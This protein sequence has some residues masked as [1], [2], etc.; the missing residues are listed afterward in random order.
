[1]ATPR[2]PT[3]ATK[4]NLVRTVEMHTGGHP[5]RIIVSGMPSFS[6]DR[7]KFEI[8]TSLESLLDAY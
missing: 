7:L 6:Y 4:S 5:L 1:M 8:K 3:E 2:E